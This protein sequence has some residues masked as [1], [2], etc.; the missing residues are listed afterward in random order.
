MNSY[1]ESLIKPDN[2]VLNYE[3]KLWI[4]GWIINEEKFCDAKT[5]DC[6]HLIFPLGHSWKF[7]M[8]I[9]IVKKKLITIKK[10]ILVSYNVASSQLII[11]IILEKAWIAWRYLYVPWLWIFFMLTW[12]NIVK[13]LIQYTVYILKLKLPFHNISLG[14]CTILDLNVWYFVKFSRMTTLEPC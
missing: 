3:E 2:S 14:Y 8:K 11:N 13:G 4:S 12:L 7:F 1:K 10:L 6:W 5:A 9:P